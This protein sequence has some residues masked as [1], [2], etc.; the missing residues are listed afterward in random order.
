MGVAA[1]KVMNMTLAT[2]ARPWRKFPQML[3]FYAAVGVLGAALLTF[4]HV[5]FPAED[6]TLPKS[7]PIENIRDAHTGESLEDFAG[8]AIGLCGLAVGV[9]GVWLTFRYGQRSIALLQRMT[10]KHE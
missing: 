7:I 1:V 8:W 4:L 3:M 6:A 9:V 5:Q 2:F 10:D